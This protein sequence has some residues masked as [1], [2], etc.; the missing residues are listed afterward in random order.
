MLALP[1]PGPF[2][3]LLLGC[4]IFGLT[5]LVLALLHRT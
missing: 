4:I 1:L 5:L 2:E 3:L